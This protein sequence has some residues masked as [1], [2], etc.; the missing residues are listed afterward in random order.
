MLPFSSHLLVNPGTQSRNETIHPT[1]P[2]MIHKPIIFLSELRINESV[3]R[4][5][6]ESLGQPE[7]EAL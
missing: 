6:S 7:M 2:G 4:S 1:E 5:R 3:S